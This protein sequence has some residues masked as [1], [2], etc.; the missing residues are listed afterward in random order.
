MIR[1]T[2][3]VAHVPDVDGLESEDDKKVARMESLKIGMAFILNR[4][5]F[6]S[7][8]LDAAELMTMM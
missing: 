7:L 8:T 3:G 6:K 2:I 5:N 1:R 4:E